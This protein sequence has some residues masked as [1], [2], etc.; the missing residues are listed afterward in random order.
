MNLCTFYIFVAHFFTNHSLSPSRVGHPDAE[1]VVLK[2]LLLHLSRIF[3]HLGLRLL[4]SLH[5]LFC[6]IRDLSGDSVVVVVVVVVLEVVVWIH[7]EHLSGF[8]FLYLGALQDLQTFFCWFS[9]EQTLLQKVI[10]FRAKLLSSHFLHLSSNLSFLLL[11]VP[12][13]LLSSFL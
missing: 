3:A 9:E 13:R 2:T 12:L 7:L 1:W 11:L 8:C 5:F 4:C 6:S 10:F